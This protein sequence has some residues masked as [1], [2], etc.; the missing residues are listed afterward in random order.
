MENYLICYD[1]GC[2]KRRRKLAKQLE[3]EAF[4]INKSVFVYL[5]SEHSIE[6]LHAELS[7]FCSKKDSVYIFPLCAACA[8]KAISMQ[9]QTK[10]RRRRRSIFV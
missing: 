6:T 7:Q 8:D 2:N 5:N 1:I 9:Q 4:R 3:K 10:S